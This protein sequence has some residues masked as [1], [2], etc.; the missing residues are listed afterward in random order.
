VRFWDS[1]ALLALL[2]GQEGS[3][4][5][6]PLAEEDAGVAIWWATPVELASGACRLLGENALEEAACARLL[7]RIAAI[8][9]AADQ[10]EAA[11]VVREA[12]VRML[13][14]HDLRAADALQLA[15][16]LVWSDYSPSGSAFVST[17]RRLRVAASREGFKVLP[18]EPWPAR[19]G[20]SASPL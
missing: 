17:D 13:R 1:S 16:A 14:V 9:R 10:I 8:A 18:E 15:S 20:G 2:A 11:E 19:S 4:L 6:K 7:D 12:A 3:A 5:L